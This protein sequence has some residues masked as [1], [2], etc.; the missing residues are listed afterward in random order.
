MRLSL[1]QAGS[2][3]F[4]S[5]QKSRTRDVA[6]SFDLEGGAILKGLGHCKETYRS[7]AL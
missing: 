5:P 4:W 7:E 6:R 1:S 3:L 2:E